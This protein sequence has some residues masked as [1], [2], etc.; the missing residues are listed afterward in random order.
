M[1]HGFT[2]KELAKK[3]AI[4]SEKVKKAL[5]KNST[6]DEDL[7]K[8]LSWLQ[9]ERKCFLNS[10]SRK[11][12]DFIQKK[13]NK[14]PSIQRAHSE[15]EH[16]MMQRKVAGF[17]NGVSNNARPHSQPSSDEMAEFYKRQKAFDSEKRLSAKLDEDDLLG[18]R[19]DNHLR[20]AWLSPPNE[21]E[22]NDAKTRP[23][24]AFGKEARQVLPSPGV[25]LPPP[26][27]PVLSRLQPPS[28]PDPSEGSRSLPC[29]PRMQRRRANTLDTPRN[30]VPSKS[31]TNLKK[32]LEFSLSMPATTRGAR[33]R[34]ESSPVDFEVSLVVKAHFGVQCQSYCSKSIP[35]TATAKQG[36]RL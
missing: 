5:D 26:R 32:T 9:K 12:L 11:K 13:C 15:A 4:C 18:S 30:L 36:T 34:A 29:S 22:N 16:A 10:L 23:G 1:A 27:S 3:D 8:G 25:S 24:N 31:W 2:F 14:L 28:S 17:C 21:D 6:Y 20:A 35:Q 19:E 7:K 33:L